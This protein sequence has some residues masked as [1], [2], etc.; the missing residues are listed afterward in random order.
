[1]TVTVCMCMHVCVCV[2]VGVGACLP[3]GCMSSSSSAKQST[4]SYAPNICTMGTE[5][6]LKGKGGRGG[7]KEGV[8]GIVID[9]AV[10]VEVVR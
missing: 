9:V 1:M 4:V 3:V 6:G 7:E 8:M 10:D 2:C 5:G